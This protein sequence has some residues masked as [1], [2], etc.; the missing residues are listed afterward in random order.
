MDNPMAKKP[1]IFLEKVNAKDYEVV[2][3]DDI[4]HDPESYEDVELYRVDRM[5]QVK[6][7]AMQIVLKEVVKPGPKPKAN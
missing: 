4:K 3:V 1:S 6:P 7:V 2:S 5:T